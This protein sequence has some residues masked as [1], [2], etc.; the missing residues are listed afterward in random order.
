MLTCHVYLHVKVLKAKEVLESGLVGQPYHAIANYW[1]AVGFSTFLDE[2][3]FFAGGNWRFDP[4][5]TGGGVLMDRATHW[6]RSLTM[7]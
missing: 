1:E 3:H 7:W 2:A 5:K 4:N 6:V